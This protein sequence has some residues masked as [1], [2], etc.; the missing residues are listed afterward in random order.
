MYHHHLHHPPIFLEAGCPSCRPTNSVK[1]LK[2]SKAR[3]SAFL[4]VYRPIQ[5]GL[6]KTVILIPIFEFLRGI[7]LT[8]AFLIGEQRLQQERLLGMVTAL[9]SLL[10]I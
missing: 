2:S 5:K 9:N 10:I 8:L 7:L 3:K 1:A 4:T 6:F